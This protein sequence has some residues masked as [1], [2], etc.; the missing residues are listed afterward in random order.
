MM[1]NLRVIDVNDN[2]PRITS[3][4]LAITRGGSDS[5]PASTAAH[6]LGRV[7]A[8]DA[9]EGVNAVV[10]FR[11]LEPSRD[12]AFRVHP[13]TGELSVVPLRPLRELLAHKYYELVIE[14]ENSRAHTPLSSNATITIGVLCFT[15]FSALRYNDNEYCPV[16]SSVQ[17]TI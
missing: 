17:F 13:E 9:D 12:T 14:A 5:A 10:R 8:V 3:S 1:K 11:V 2:A 4:R 6:V 7:E 16:L 15:V